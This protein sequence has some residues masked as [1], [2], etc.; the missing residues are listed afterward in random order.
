MPIFEDPDIVQALMGNR[1]DQLRLNCLDWGN[2][3]SFPEDVV[4]QI[5]ENLIS[6]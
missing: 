6:K 3:D 4:G 1:Y 2:N 5:A